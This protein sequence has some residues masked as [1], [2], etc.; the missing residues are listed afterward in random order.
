MD[1]IKELVSLCRIQEIAHHNAS[2][3]RK[4]PR[5]VKDKNLENISLQYKVASIKPTLKNIQVMRLLFSI[6]LYLM[7]EI[8]LPVTRG[9]NDSPNL[10]PLV[11]WGKTRVD[12][13]RTQEQSKVQCAGRE[14][15][16]PKKL[17][18]FNHNCV[19]Q[20]IPA[21]KKRRPLTADCGE[22]QVQLAK[23]PR[24]GEARGGG[25]DCNL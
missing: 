2:Q 5:P 17:V 23:V 4:K 12:Q 9:R 1:R 16:E 24:M 18:C 7:F 20:S 22:P 13:R 8:R 14:R 19:T 25:A 10:E 21:A 11:R 6:R 15:V 3:A